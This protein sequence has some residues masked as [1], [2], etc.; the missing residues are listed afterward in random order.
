MDK[1]KFDKNTSLGLKGVA[2]LLMLLHHNFS[3]R[4]LSDK[5][6][7]SFF[8]FRKEWILNMAD[9]SKICV[10]I[11]AFISGY[12][13][14]LSYKKS[15]IDSKKWIFC[16]YV[17]TFSGYWFIWILSCVITQMINGRYTIKFGNSNIWQMVADSVIDFLGLANLFGTPTLNGT[18]WY[19]SAAAVFIFLVPVLV[20]YEKDLWLIAGG[21][22]IIWRMILQAAGGN[23]FPGTISVYA[24]LLPYLLG[25]IFAKNNYVEMIMNN[26]GKK[27]RLFLEIFLL[28]I[29]YKIYVNIST[30]TY[31][32]IKWGLIPLLVILF[33]SEYLLQIS[34]IRKILIFLGKHSMNI[35]MVHTFIRAFYLSDFI[36]SWKNFMMITMILLLISLAIS[37][38]LELLKKLIRYEQMIESICDKIEAM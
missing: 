11:F 10:S 6:A 19:M 37:M 33:S 8:P 29:S 32:E 31:W 9:M 30:E 3:I 36:Y 7:I 12:G 35:F 26:K 18:W 22:V 13:L 34:W 16:R 5:Y 17:K 23:A 2:I 1:L 25:M 14:Y 4:S 20:K 15:R 27:L 38:I 24:F 21:S 28:M